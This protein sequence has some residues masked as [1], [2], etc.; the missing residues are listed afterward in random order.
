MPAVTILLSLLGAAGQPAPESRAD[1]R[2]VASLLPDSTLLRGTVEIAFMPAWPADTLWLHLYPNAYRDPGTM[3]AADLESW[4]DYSFAGASPDEY[5]WI[6]LS[7]WELDGSPVEVG[8]DGTIGFVPLS[9]PA[10]PGDTLRLRGGFSVGVPVIWSRMGRDGS[11][12]EMSQWYPRMCVLDDMGWH[13]GR[14]RSEGEFYGDFGSFTVVL[15]LPDSFVTAATGSRR[16][17][18]WSPDSL[19]RTE[20]WVAED[21]HDFAWA[22]DPAFVVTDHVF[23]ND[24][25]GWHPVRVHIAVQEC[26]IDD[27]GEVAAW[28]DSTLLY[29]GEWYMPYAYDDLWIVQSATYGGM[30]YPQF[31]LAGPWQVPFHRY[32]EMVVIHEVGHQWFYGMLGSDEVD[33]AWL[34]EGINTF[35]ELRYFDRRYGPRG[36]MTTLPRWVADYSDTDETSASYTRMVA[37]GEDFPVLSTSTDAAG[38]V[39]DYG[40]LYYSKPAL[41]VRMLQNQMGGE[42]FDA[43]MR[44]YC[45]RFAFHHPGTGDL[46]AVIEEVSGR[47]WA[48]EFETWLCT[49]ASA[50]VSVA[51]IEWEGDSTLVT[52]RADIPLPAVLDLGAGRGGASGLFRVP[53]EPATTSVA[54]IPGRWD[55]VEL[56]PGTN[57]PDRNPW[58]NSLPSSGSVRPM[59]YPYEQPSRFNTWL[60]PVPGWAGGR[61]EL[62]LFGISRAASLGSGGPFELEGVW[63]Q[64]LESGG[65]GVFGLA[66]AT[67]PERSGEGGTT[68]SFD[69]W[70]GYGMARARIRAVRSI[71][72]RRF[73]EPAA[74]LW[75]GIGLEGVSDIAS[76]PGEGEYGEGCGAILDLG[77]STSVRNRSGSRRAGVSVRICPDWSGEPWI[78]ARCE[79]VLTLESVPLSPGTRLFAG[80]VWGNAA[81]QHLFRAGGGLAPEGVLGWLLPVDGEFS[82]L[83]GYF[84]ES[85]P[86]LPGYGGRYGNIGIGL[87]ETLRIPPLPLTLFADAG[88]VV[89]SAGGITM[90]NALADAGIGILAG[91]ATIWLP[92]WVSDPPDDEDEWELRW[93]ASFSLWGLS[94]LLF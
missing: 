5:G 56:D 26:S 70:S 62:G 63:R 6:D 40:A 15:S 8:V 16:S 12:Y 4:G 28:A 87:G 30:E 37:R 10:A 81:P 92:A 2:I 64:P 93:R 89:G 19:V 58:N 44:E 74:D 38:G 53:L 3:F 85:G 94:A 72:G 22:A 86:A 79:A 17:V 83:Q 73:G 55:R 47:S 43:A 59:L 29:Y 20:T 34:D 25:A 23:R 32:F 36:N 11:H 50:D 84:V 46:R 88:W 60:V 31:V 67:S 54:A 39:R 57:Y 18:L 27:W 71:G 52:I 33:E 82:P 35:S 9:S 13:L 61:W 90:D 1:Y 45:R 75:A 77:A 51:G 78:Q 49:T 21:V 48:A 7:G 24:A 42:V 65:T 68:L 80:R 91:F 14:Y 66:A 41:F 76:V 69:A